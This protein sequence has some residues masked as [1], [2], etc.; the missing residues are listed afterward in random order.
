MNVWGLKND[1]CASAHESNL[2]NRSIKI[3]KSKAKTVWYWLT[4]A[5]TIFHILVTIYIVLNLTEY[6]E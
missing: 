2:L 6:K 5:K 3:S 1:K 4:E